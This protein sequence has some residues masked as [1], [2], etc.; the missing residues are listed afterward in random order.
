MWKIRA[1]L[2][3][4]ETETK[5]Y[6]REPQAAGWTFAFPIFIL[7]LFMFIW[8]KIP[9]YISFI[10]PGL[11]GVSVASAS[12]YGLGLVLVVYRQYGYLKRIRITPLPPIFY[13]TGML[14]SRL[15][16]MM[17]ST[18]AL[19]VLAVAFF[20][21][22]SKNLWLFFLT[23]VFG[24]VTFAFLGLLIASLCKTV[25][26]A[27]AVTHMVFFPMIFLSN[28]FIPSRFF[29]EFLK[30]VSLCFPLTHF[31]ELQRSALTG[32]QQGESIWLGFVVVGLFM[33]VG[34]VL[35]AQR[36]K[37]MDLL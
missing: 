13:I 31:I 1:L 28:A 11:V 32:F 25:D 16:V 18:L 35:S 27:S 36:M 9:G 24:A 33:A 10:A 34:A 14:L 29:P 2:R 19:V 30:K 3:I 15:I 17:M 4:A 26:S 20:N 7:L 8:G 5:L 12:F 37:T 22:D 23:T 21:L 6:L